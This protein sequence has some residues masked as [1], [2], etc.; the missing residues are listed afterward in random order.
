MT[1]ALNEDTIRDVVSEVLSR[2]GQG[3]PPAAKAPPRAAGGELGVFSRVDDAVAAAAGAQ[4]QLMNQTLDDRA[5][6]VQCIRDIVINQAEEL[7]RIELEETKIGRLD[8]KIEKIVVV[9]QKVP[10]MEM[11]RTEAVSGDPGLCV[12][13]YAP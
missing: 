6:A 13:A 12:T 5:T 3:G 9:G 4:R 11:L 10:G 7:G 1:A 8:H 2:L